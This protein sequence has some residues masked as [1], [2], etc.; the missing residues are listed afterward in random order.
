MVTVAVP[1][2]T[3]PT[4]QVG[5]GVAVCATEHERVTS[6]ELNPF[7]GAIVTI[8]VDDPPGCTE[9]GDRAASVSEKLTATGAALD[10]LAAKL[11]LLPPL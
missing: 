1:F 2:V 6:D 5:A 8:E 9:P 3:E 4:V 11:L 10:V 7:V